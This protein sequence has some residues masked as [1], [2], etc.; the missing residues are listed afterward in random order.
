MIQDRRLGIHQPPCFLSIAGR[1]SEPLVPFIID[2]S[3]LFLEAIF[4]FLF[5]FILKK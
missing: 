3:R 4:F 2:K 1:D 5:N